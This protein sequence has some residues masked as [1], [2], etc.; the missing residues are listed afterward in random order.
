MCKATGRPLNYL[1]QVYAPLDEDLTHEQAFHRALFLF[2]T[3]KVML[4]RMKRWVIDLH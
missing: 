1:L 3:P 4:H 2:V